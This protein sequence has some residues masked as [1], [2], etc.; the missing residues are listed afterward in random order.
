MHL[1]GRAPPGADRSAELAAET[2]SMRA[3]LLAAL[4]L[5]GC[6]A[7]PGATPSAATPATT[8][9]PAPTA[10]VSIA[11]PTAAPTASPTANTVFT[12][13]DAE[14]A[15]LVTAGA[16]EAIPQLKVLNDSDPSRLEALF[17]PLGVW[18][19]RQQAGLEPYTASNCT[20]GAVERFIEGLF[21]YDVI[22][23]QFLAWRD[24]GAVGHAFPPGAPREAAESFEE[25]LVELEAHCTAGVGP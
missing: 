23:K 22:R 11:S 14:I 6:T 15:R 9:S 24:W 18:I 13:D 12:T 3:L 25:S 10:S 17:Q 20:S 7:G 1:A 8:G 16:N 2:H 4:L 19:T 21:R 5:A